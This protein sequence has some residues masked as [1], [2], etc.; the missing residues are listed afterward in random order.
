MRNVIDFP[1]HDKIKDLTD[2][3]DRWRRDHCAYEDLRF[4]KRRYQLNQAP[5]SELALL[6]AQAEFRRVF[7][8]EPT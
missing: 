6:D 5:E 7:A 3:A 4:A 8:G 2:L 1:R